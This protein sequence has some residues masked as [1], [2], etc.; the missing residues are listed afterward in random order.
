MS[1]FRTCPRCGMHLD[2]GEVCDCTKKELSSVVT[3]EQPETD[4]A[5]IHT[6]KSTIIITDKEERRQAFDDI[7]R[8]ISKDGLKLILTALQA[9]SEKRE[10]DEVAAIQQ[11]SDDDI[12]LFIAAMEVGLGL[13]VA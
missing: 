13:D 12:E 2:P 5:S 10:D 1:Y 9:K 4:S 6:T 3:T 11:M 7:M 8:Q